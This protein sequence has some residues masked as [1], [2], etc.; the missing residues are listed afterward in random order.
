M[1]LRTDLADAVDIGKYLSGFSDPVIYYVCDHL[2]PGIFYD[3]QGNR[4]PCGNN[5]T[6]GGLV[7]KC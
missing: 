1:S 3:K 5:G 6:T 2:D 7:I 4:K